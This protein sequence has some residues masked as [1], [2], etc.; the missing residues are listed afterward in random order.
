LDENED[1][2]EPTRRYWRWYVRP[3]FADDDGSQTTGAEQQLDT[4]LESTERFARSLVEKLVSEPEQACSVIFAAKRHD[5]GK[6][7]LLWQ[8][9]IGNRNPAVWLA[10][11]SNG[12]RSI[13]ITGYR[14]EFGSLLDILSD[15]EF[16][17]LPLEAQELVLHL[18]AAHHGR[19][20]PHF[21]NDEAFDP[22]NSKQ[23]SDE[24]AGEVPGRY[25]R[26]QRKY[27]RWGLAY[28]E[29]LVRTADAL[30]SQSIE[31]TQEPAQVA[32]Q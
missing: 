18:I 17:R 23:R 7:R 28:L 26:L 16:V 2:E 8:R 19:A 27:G 24:M 11:S 13:Q 6:R 25:A 15:P 14:H 32:A 12:A 30:A 20:R 31:L 4:H 29:S 1:E 22:E 9:S 5:V 3:K 21:P 10:K